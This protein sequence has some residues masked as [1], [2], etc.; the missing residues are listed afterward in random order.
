MVISIGQSLDH[1]FGSS[2]KMLPGVPDQ[3]LRPKNFRKKLYVI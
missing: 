3:N 2:L 1:A